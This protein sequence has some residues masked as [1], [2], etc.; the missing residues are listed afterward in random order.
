MPPDLVVKEPFKLKGTRYKRGDIISDPT[1]V[2]AL[3]EHLKR[4]VVPRAETPAPARPAKRE[5]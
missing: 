4:H 5:G 2:A 3:P 1:M